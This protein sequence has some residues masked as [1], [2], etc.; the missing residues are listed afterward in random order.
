VYSCEQNKLNFSVFVHD[1]F[2]LGSKE[3]HQDKTSYK[4]LKTVEQSKNKNR[5]TP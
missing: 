2:G 5:G 1:E 3:K 4:Q